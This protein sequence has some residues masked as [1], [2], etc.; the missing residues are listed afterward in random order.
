MKKLLIGL[1][2]LTS[3]SAF[4][5]LGDSDSA[6]TIQPG[7]V[8]TLSRDIVIPASNKILFK[9]GVS[10]KYFSEVSSG[11]FCHLAAY[12]ENGNEFGKEVRL[13]AGAGLEVFRNIPNERYVTIATTTPKGNLVYFDCF[14]SMVGN[15]GTKTPAIG[16]IKKSFI[17]LMDLKL[18]ITE[19]TDI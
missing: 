11:P 14:H 17:N 13:N 1:L 15:L 8:F 18:K 10:Y 9:D 3:I 2:T 16:E 12:D 5:D 19:P 6:I 4:A 7:S